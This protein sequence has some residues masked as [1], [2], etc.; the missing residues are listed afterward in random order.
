MYQN[1]TK[2]ELWEYLEKKIIS[3]VETTVISVQ[4]VYLENVIYSN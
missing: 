3:K 1:S 2:L 4:E